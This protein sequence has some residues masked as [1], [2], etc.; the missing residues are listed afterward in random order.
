MTEAKSP[1]AISPSAR[2]VVVACKVP[3]GMC[4]QLQEPAQRMEDTRDGP[5]ARTY[6]AKR[7]RPYYVHGPAY[8]VGTLPKGFPRPPLIE[9]GYAITRGIPVEFWEAW[10]EQNKRADYFMTP[11]GAEHGMIFAYADMDDTIA[12]AREQEK[13][14]SGL[15]PLSTDEDRDG[16]LTDPRLPRPV[17]LAVAKLAHEPHPG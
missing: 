12:A 7:G 3:N 8:P 17:N 10:A 9:G 14:L 5:V 1:K 13:L 16:K 15:E 11:D 4:L 2:T 6:W